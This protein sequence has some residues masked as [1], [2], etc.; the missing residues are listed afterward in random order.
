ML[1]DAVIHNIPVKNG[2]YSFLYDE[3]FFIV[4]I[5]TKKWKSKKKNT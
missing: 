5:E 4:N 3:C 2:D 1:P